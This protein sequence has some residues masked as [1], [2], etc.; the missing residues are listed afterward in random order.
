[1]G[2]REAEGRPMIHRA[3]GPDFTPMPL[4]HSLDRRQPDAGA[5]ELALIVQPLERGKQMA[6]ACHVESRAVVPHE[7]GSRPI[8]L[9]QSAKFNPRAGTPGR[10]L[11]C[12]AHQVL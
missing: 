9:R 1:M 3:F 10:E 11:P 4:Y 2:Q 7:I 5:T 6:G 12:V 8:A